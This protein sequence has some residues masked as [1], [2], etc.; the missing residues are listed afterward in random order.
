M[1]I[2]GKIVVV[3]GAGSGIG[4]AS[5]VAFAAGGAA[6]VA[7]A[8]VDAGGADET[9]ALVKDAGADALIVA[10]DVSVPDEV[11]A[12]FAEVERRWGG[13]DIVHNNA[14]LA[15][16]DPPWPGTS[17]E[18][19]RTVL[20]VNVG[21][22]FYGTRLA[23][24]HL[25]RRGGGAVVNTASVAGLAPMPDDAVYAATKAAVISFTQSCA[26][27]KASHNI[28]VNAVL[29]GVVDTPMIAKTGDGTRKAAWLS[30]VLGDAEIA[31]K[32]Q[33]VAEAVIALVRD[34][35]KA[36]ETIVLIAPP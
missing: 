32:P 36:G 15:S 5:A 1:D 17:V 27:L 31:L 7:I 23:V 9:A 21:G 4:R 25:Q 12:L 13:V 11:G 19:M 29:P 18:R 34:D 28:C 35:T 8:D 6:G 22:V 14:G 20:N 16:G 2:K 26:P 30:A 24:N 10:T 3:T 33:H